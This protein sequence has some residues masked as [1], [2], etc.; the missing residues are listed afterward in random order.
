MGKVF[1]L[2]SIKEINAIS[3]LS[4]LQLTLLSLVV[5]VRRSGPDMRWLISCPLAEHKYTLCASASGTYLCV[6]DSMSALV[7]AFV[8]ELLH[9]FLC[10]FACMH[11]SACAPNWIWA[12]F[13]MYWKLF[14]EWP[15]KSHA[16]QCSAVVCVRPPVWFRLSGESPGTHQWPSPAYRAPQ[17]E[18]D[19]LMGQIWRHCGRE[20][21]T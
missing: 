11:I 14:L 12:F 1:F 3:R 15:S 7:R 4:F 6:F 20:E 10:P 19:S 18:E 21:V 16:V 13:F 8:H 9:V 5:N 17:F 2:P